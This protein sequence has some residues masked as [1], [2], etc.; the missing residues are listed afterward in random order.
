MVSKIKKRY[1]K[2]KALYV[3]PKGDG[4]LVTVNLLKQIESQINVSTCDLKKDN[5]AFNLLAKR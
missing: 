1:F 4:T 5:T 3:F 2:L